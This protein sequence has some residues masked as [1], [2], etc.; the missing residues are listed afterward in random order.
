MLFLTLEGLFF[1]FQ[2]AI[3]IP[4][5]FHKYTLQKEKKKKKETQICWD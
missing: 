5:D 1:L 4:L 2:L 3:K